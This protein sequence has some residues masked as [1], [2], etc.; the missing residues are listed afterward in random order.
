M[1]QVAHVQAC[2][3]CANFYVTGAEVEFVH[4]FE[5]LAGLEEQLDFV[6]TQSVAWQLHI[7]A[8]DGLPQQICANCFAQFCNIHSFRQQC[9]L[10]QQKLLQSFVGVGL[11]ANVATVAGGSK[12]AS[13]LS[14][15][16]QTS[17]ALTN[18][19]DMLSGLKIDAPVTSAEL[20]ASL[21][22]LQ[23]PTTSADVIA[24]LDGLQLPASVAETLSLLTQELTTM[25]NG[26]LLDNSAN[27]I[28]TYATMDTKTEETNVL[29]FSAASTAQNIY[30]AQ[31][32]PI[33]TVTAATNTPVTLITNAS[34]KCLGSTLKNAKPDI[35]LEDM[36]QGSIIPKNNKSNSVQTEIYDEVREE[37]HM[38]QE[39]EQMVQEEAQMVQGEA[40]MVQEEKEKP[41]STYEDM[42]DDELDYLSCSEQE[43]SNEMDDVETEADG[44][45]PT[46]ISRD[47]FACQYCYCPNS[48]SIDHLVFESA[49]A[50]S[51]HFFDVHDPNL[52]YTCPYC[53]QKY[54]SAKQRDYHV[55]L[56]HPTVSR[57]DQCEYCKK[58][59]R[60][61]KECHE[62]H[63]QYVGDWRCDTCEQCFYQFPL[64]RFRA[65][66]RHHLNKKK[67][68]CR[69]CGRIFVRRANLEAHERLH[70]PRAN[71]KIECHECQEVFSNDYELRRHKYQAHNGALPVRC[72]YCHKGFV[73][74]A[75]LS[76]HRQHFHPEKT[77]SNSL[78]SATCTNC[79][80][81]FSSLQK[82]RLHAQQPR[83]EKG[84]CIET[85]RQ[86]IP[87]QER[88]RQLR[89]P[90][91]YSCEHCN[92]RFSTQATLDKH[93]GTHGTVTFGCSEC[94]MRFQD[95]NELK[96]HIMEMHAK[97]RYLK[98]DLCEKR[99]CYMRELQQHQ[100]EHA[101]DGEV[102]D[103][104]FHCPIRNCGARA[105]SIKEAH[106]HAYLNHKLIACDYCDCLFGRNRLTTHLRTVHATGNIAEEPNNNNNNSNAM[107]FSNA[108]VASRQTEDS[109]AVASIL[110]TDNVQLNNN[111][112]MVSFEDGAINGGEKVRVELVQ[113]QTPIMTNLVLQEQVSN[114]YKPLIPTA[115]EMEQNFLMGALL[116]QDN[117]IIVT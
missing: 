7:S 15:Q 34:A 93:M 102:P 16:S 12:Q 31:Q 97:P 67:L 50:L 94:S 4:L 107:T 6:R 63:C 32:A 111:D 58:T 28:T 11:N 62:M 51:Q 113:Q 36:L 33:T 55:R 86:V 59:L 87:Y 10:A 17:A 71:F 95:A 21:D 18:G 106:D 48:G 53:P 76:R 39:E 22:C 13:S 43:E 40:Q 99:F 5:P 23:P 14:P 75:F 101:G 105:S 77:G 103:D 88:T 110:G 114:T 73:S 108:Q 117:E 74:M 79:G 70:R 64:N 37:T 47:P 56:M 92:K 80:C 8:N 66:Q 83:D 9:V 85:M 61:T 45:S 81:V 115:D 69:E 90:R 26:S 38:V 57:A 82:L 27:S 60:S 20:M 89:R 25:H 35:D 2:R 68:R 84:H 3:L 98:C 42:M 78:G 49:D 44:T 109:L 52:P 116:D 1:D 96:R 41:F 104:S 65:H 29:Q 100:K 19:N 72:E 24:C 54:N 112:L 91:L 30:Y 46:R